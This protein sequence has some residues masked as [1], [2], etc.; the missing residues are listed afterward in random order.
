MI[1]LLRKDV[2]I[3]ENGFVFYKNLMLRNSTA[4]G[5]G[6]LSDIMTPMDGF[7]FHEHY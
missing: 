1:K 5:D 7:V 2:S 6:F 3:Y 4:C